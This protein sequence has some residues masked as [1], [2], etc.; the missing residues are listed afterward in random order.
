MKKTNA[1]LITLFKLLKVY[2]T[3]KDQLGRHNVFYFTIIIQSRSLIIIYSQAVMY[4]IFFKDSDINT[5]ERERETFSLTLL[6]VP[7]V[8]LETQ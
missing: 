2:L 1:K 5:S 4:I 7:G 6:A 3:F 8:V